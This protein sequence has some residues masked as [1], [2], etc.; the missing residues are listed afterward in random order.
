MSDTLTAPTINPVRVARKRAL[1]T[2]LCHLSLWVQNRAKG[3]HDPRTTLSILERKI[4]DLAAQVARA[5]QA[6]GARDGEIHF[7]LTFPG[8]L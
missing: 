4:E 3:D 7:D 6:A 2:G 1:D 5:G 8:A